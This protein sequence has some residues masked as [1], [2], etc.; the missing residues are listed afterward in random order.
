MSSR[1]KRRA[2]VRLSD[3]KWRSG[4][5]GITVP[6]QLSRYDRWRRYDLLRNDM[7]NLGHEPGMAGQALRCQKNLRRHAHEKCG[8]LDLGK[9]LGWQARRSWSI[10]CLLVEMN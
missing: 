6:N 9:Y 2:V 1:L 4:G 3:C 7:L 8:M 5:T 10:R